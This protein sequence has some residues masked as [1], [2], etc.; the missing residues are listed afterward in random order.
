MHPLKQS[1]SSAGQLKI[2][3]SWAVSHLSIHI[4][5][6]SRTLKPIYAQFLVEVKVN[7]DGPLTESGWSKNDEMWTK[8]M[9]NESER[10]ESTQCRRLAGNKGLNS[11]YF[12][13]RP[14]HLKNIRSWYLKIYR[15]RVGNIRSF[16]VKYMVPKVNKWVISWQ[17]I[18]GPLA[19]NIRSLSIIRDSR[20]VSHHWLTNMR[21]ITLY[22]PCAEK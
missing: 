12:V 19:E 4:R 15:P 9:V 14:G 18:N 11:P 6:K 1:T 2:H 10:S 17:K 20:I 16:G 22:G 8:I 5:F 3:W 13:E 7:V 21:K